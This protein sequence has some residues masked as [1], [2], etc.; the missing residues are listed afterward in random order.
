MTIVLPSLSSPSL[1]LPVV[2]AAGHHEAVVPVLNHAGHLLRAAG[3]G[4]PV[5]LGVRAVLLEAVEAGES[6]V[7]GRHVG[8]DLSGE[9]LVQ[10][11]VVTEILLAQTDRVVQ[12]V[13]EHAVLPNLGAREER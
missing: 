2:V 9:V 1:D 7:A 4:L 12:T 10:T 13:S 11:E 8:R 5:S 6:V 3:L